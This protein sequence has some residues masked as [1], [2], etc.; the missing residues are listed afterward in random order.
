MLKHYPIS[1]IHDLSLPPLDYGYKFEVDGQ[2]LD[3]R[4]IEEKALQESANDVRVLF[5]MCGAA[6]G[7]PN[8]WSSRCGRAC[9]IASS[10]TRRPPP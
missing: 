1:T 7:S 3:L 6:R 2:A 10:A 4:T 5:A 8:F 9:W